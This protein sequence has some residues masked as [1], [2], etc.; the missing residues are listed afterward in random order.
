[1]TAARSLRRKAF[2]EM[3]AGCAILTT[4]FSEL[5]WAVLPPLDAA[6]HA[7]HNLLNPV[8]LTII[9]A[10]LSE[11]RIAILHLGTPCS[12]FSRALNSD[13]IT[14]VRSFLFPMGFD[15]LSDV[16]RAKCDLGNALAEV[17]AVLWRAQ[18]AAGGGG[19][20]VGTPKY[21]PGCPPH[22]SRPDFAGC[23]RCDY[24]SL[25]FRCS[26]EEGHHP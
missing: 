6:K 9:L 7:C 22:L 19:G 12:S 3:F 5:G 14:A 11:G 26:L 2:W 18:V 24:T 13:F 10:I 21:L 4:I 15:D 23:F 8:F 25:P 17:S 1:M 16:K 20:P